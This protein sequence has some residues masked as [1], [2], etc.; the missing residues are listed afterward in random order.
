MTFCQEPRPELTEAE[1]AALMADT[2]ARIAALYANFFLNATA[3]TETTQSAR[4]EHL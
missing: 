3:T 2:K 1:A 4:G